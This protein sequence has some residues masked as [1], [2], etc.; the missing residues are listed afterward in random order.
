MLDPVSKDIKMAGKNIVIIDSH[1][2]LSMNVEHLFAIC[3]RGYMLR[4]C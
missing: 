2:L 4:K 1:G 3:W